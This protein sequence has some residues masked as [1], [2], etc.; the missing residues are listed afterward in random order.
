[1]R[2]TGPGGAGRPRPG[3]AV[4]QRGERDTVQLPA[5]VRRLWGSLARLPPAP[6]GRTPA[7]AFRSGSGSGSQLLPWRRFLSAQRRHGRP[8]LPRAP[9]RSRWMRS[10]ADP[11]APGHC[12]GGGAER[13]RLC[14]RL[15]VGKWRKEQ[16]PLLL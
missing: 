16:G 8:R 7:A 14:F 3:G 4:S 13:P 2:G 12:P 15:G 5:L 11:A 9:R 6:Q 10:P 1:M